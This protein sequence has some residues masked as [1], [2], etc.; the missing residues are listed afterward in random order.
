MSC[1]AW[2]PTHELGYDRG[3]WIPVR[4]VTPEDRRQWADRVEVEAVDGT[5]FTVTKDTSIRKRVRRFRS[6]SP[7]R[8]AS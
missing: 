1:R 7:C 4:Y 2:L 3:V 8:L 6:K 5:R